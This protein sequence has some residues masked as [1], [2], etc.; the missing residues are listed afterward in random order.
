MTA[1]YIRL[2][3]EKKG[4]SALEDCEEAIKETRQELEREV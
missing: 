4:L 2:C 1:E 3:S